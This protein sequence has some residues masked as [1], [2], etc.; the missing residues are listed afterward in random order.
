MKVLAT[1]VNKKL[2][3]KLQVLDNLSYEM[4]KNGYTSKTDM[5]KWY[6]SPEKVVRHIENDIKAGYYEGFVKIEGEGE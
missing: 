5:S 6:V 4:T 3:A 1:Y 2:G